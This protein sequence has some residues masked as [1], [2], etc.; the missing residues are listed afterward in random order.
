MNFCKCGCG[1]LVE[2][3]YKKGH[4]R[5]GK[6]NSE[7]HNLVISK[8]NKGRKM[9]KFLKEK[10][11]LY[12]LG[13][14]KTDAEKLKQSIGAKKA[15]VGKWM[16]GRK[17][18]DKTKKKLSEI[19]KGHFVSEET[20]MKI[21]G[22]NSGEHNGMFGVHHN[23][24]VRKKIS[25]A[26]KRMWLNDH[27]REVQF[28]IRGGTDFKKSARKGALIA[29]FKIGKYDTVPERKVAV[30][31]KDLDVKFIHPY[32][33]W[34]INHAYAA[35]FFIPEINLIIEVDGVYWHNY[36]VG[37]EIDKIRDEELKRVG[38][39]VSRIWEVDISVEKMVNI[40]SEG[41]F[42]F[43]LTE[44]PN[45]YIAL[46]KMEK[47][48]HSMQAETVGV[49]TAEA[50]A[51]AVA[52]HEKRATQRQAYHR[53]HVLEHQHHKDI[54]EEQGYDVRSPIQKTAAFMLTDEGFEKPQ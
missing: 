3:N 4:G 43:C 2:K 37:R 22:A 50:L 34:N 53:A 20:R 15:G 19:H 40:L 7:A 54:M 49:V 26:S 9:P 27:F 52:E 28:E 48:R 51:G 1:F 36:P 21:S 11:R 31:L 30:I 12:H 17:L 38:Y 45:Y 46:E 47:K 33:V 23:E 41:G 16:L 6:I 14:K 5:R 42:K 29:S 39:N 25:D 32:S 18:S 24:C 8:A 10:L 35:D 44:F 13:R